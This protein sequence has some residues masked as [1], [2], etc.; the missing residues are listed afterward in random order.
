MKGDYLQL[1][2]LDLVIPNQ[3]MPE[4]Y[5]NFENDI[6]AKLR[7]S[8]HDLKKNIE[9]DSGEWKLPAEN[10]DKKNCQAKDVYINW[11]MR[12]YMAQTGIRRSA[13]FK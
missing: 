5:W 6:L 4:R 2:Q 3:S 11:R 8:K 13:S 9:E 1:Q 12:N 10:D 7:F